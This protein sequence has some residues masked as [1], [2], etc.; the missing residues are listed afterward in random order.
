MTNPNPPFELTVQELRD[1]LDKL[2]AK[3]LGD[4]VV[5][6]PYDPGHSTIGASP[7]VG[8]TTITAGFDWN[9]HKVFLNPTKRL[10]VPDDQLRTLVQEA[11]RKVD[12]MHMLIYRLN[13]DSPIP[14]DEQ[15]DSLK[16]NIQLLGQAKSKKPG[17]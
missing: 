11:Q 2:C 10:G 7:S 13:P 3:G 16:S 4:K 17:R 5:S 14:M 1:A 8:V 12:K 15:L 6:I 9:H